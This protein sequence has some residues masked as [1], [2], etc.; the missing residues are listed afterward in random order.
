MKVK[1]QIV[2]PVPGPSSLTPPYPYSQ[3]LD[4]FCSFTRSLTS[5]FFLLSPEVQWG[6]AS[7]I[8]I[9][10]ANV[11]WK[12]HAA[13]TVPPWIG[14]CAKPEKGQEVGGCNFIARRSTWI[15]FYFP[16]SALVKL[17][18]NATDPNQQT[19]DTCFKPHRST[20]VCVSA[21]VSGPNVVCCNR[22]IVMQSLSVFKSSS[23]TDHM[24]SISSCHGVPGANWG[25]GH[26]CCI[27]E[28]EVALMF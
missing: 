1:H 10:E 19:D 13:M 3:M 14:S 27:R 2:T 16:D 24:L 6:S 17:P 23:T 15:R 28:S 9:E 20:P 12:L 26:T 5:A 18:Q 11:K 4:I 7:E 21:A 22:S 25:R 8:I